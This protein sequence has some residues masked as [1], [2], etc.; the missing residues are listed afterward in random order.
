MWESGLGDE[1][2]ISCNSME[3]NPLTVMAEKKDKLCNQLPLF[4]P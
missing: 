4:Y 1:E 3:S 2:E